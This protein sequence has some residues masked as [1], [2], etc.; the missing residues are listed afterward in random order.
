MQ[1][2]LLVPLRLRVNVGGVAA[3]RPTAIPRG[4]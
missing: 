1:I 3:E 2:T 4:E